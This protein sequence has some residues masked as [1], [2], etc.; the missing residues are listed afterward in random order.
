MTARPAHEDLVTADGV[1]L[2]VREAGEGRPL[3]LVHG[4]LDDHR[5]WL[6]AEAELSRDHRVISYARRGHADSEDGAG[7]GARRDDEDDLAALLEELALAPATV[8]A[9]S[10][11]ASVALGLV[12]RRPE[13]VS[14]LCAHEPPLLDLAADDPAVA[15]ARR[16]LD[17]VRARIE[18][19]DA[20]AAVRDFVDDV[21]L[22]PGAWSTLGPDEQAGMV[23]AAGT[24][25][26]ELRDRDWATL[27]TAALADAGCRL[28]LTTGDQSPS[29][30]TAITRRLADT[31]G[32]AEVRT[33]AGAGH[34]PHLTHA[35]AY[36]GTVRDFVAASEPFPP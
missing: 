15:S 5:T 32:T 22:G 9:N 35:S 16:S 14:T 8:V 6:P 31:A 21:V 17:A 23:A 26:E 19:D 13:L 30:L 2:R 36:A 11:G 27:D 1:R 24:F 33:V 3:V 7:P 18:A 28:L 4:S 29:F 20:E 12:A 25:A 34:V 10:F